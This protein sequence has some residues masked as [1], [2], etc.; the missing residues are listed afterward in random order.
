MTA[1][2]VVAGEA[3]EYCENVRAWAESVYRAI[4]YPP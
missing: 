4:T 1:A 2:D 3:E